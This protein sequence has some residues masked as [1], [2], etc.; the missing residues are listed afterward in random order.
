[1]LEWLRFIVFDGDKD[2]LTDSIKKN[3]FQFMGE[4]FVPKSLD[5]EMKT[6]SFLEQFCTA[7]KNVLK[8]F[9]SIENPLGN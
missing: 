8:D 9:Q 6:W 1:M 5:L 3:G 4:G 2:E 7:K